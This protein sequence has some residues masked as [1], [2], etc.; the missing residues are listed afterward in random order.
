MPSD[1]ASRAC[2]DGVCSAGT[3]TDGIK[4]NDETD[5][6]CG[7]KSAP[8]C[9]D[10][11][12]CLVNAD[13]M[14][15]ACLSGR[16]GST[17]SDGIRDGD[18]TDVDCG[19][20]VAPACGTGKH[21]NVAR[22][23][24]SSV[25]MGTSCA[26]PS[27]TD[28]VKNGD[29]TDVDCGGSSAPKCGVGKGCKVSADCTTACTYQ[30]KC[31]SA[32]SCVAHHGGDTCGPGPDGD[33]NGTF[34]DCCISLPAT[35]QAGDPIV[36]DKYLITSGRLRAFVEATNGDVQGFARN[37]PQSNS[38]W[39]H[40]WDQ[41]L[42][43][44][45]AVVDQ[46]LG[47]FPYANTPENDPPD[48]GANFPV[49]FQRGQWRLGC[50][51]IDHGARTW[52]AANPV[53]GDVNAG[54]QDEL[55]EKAI[56]CIDAYFL[57]AFCIWDGGHLATLEELAGPWLA[58]GGKWPW[59]DRAASVD[60]VDN[61]PQGVDAQGRNAEDYIVH[62]FCGSACPG[63]NAEEQQE[64][65]GPFTY[66]YPAI[67]PSYEPAS[68][69]RHV[70]APGRK[71]LGNAKTGH[72]D[73]AGAGFSIT[74]IIQDPTLGERT[75]FVTSG[76]WEIHSLAPAPDLRDTGAVAAWWAYWAGVGRCAR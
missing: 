28:G 41:H 51:N 26:A 11:K 6:D 16:C 33:P 7:G 55:D 65:I 44:S 30:S 67:G 75:S 5:V 10:S 20:T 68:N 56:N 38:F 31:A 69:I 15:N 71:P 49:G 60:I 29:E 74:A 73:L 8:K 1:C 37:I 40:T 34:E 32:P 21:C 39:N 62:E 24:M 72:A 22:D 47:P 61:V 2:K 19:G 63:T 58:S 35:T 9:A 25:C 17:S 23:C 50:K 27:H 3:A 36:L 46:A 57:S 18:E 43:V 66:T 59:S 70:P 76:S 52:F 12:T 48:S 45:K 14:S 53:Q 42:P 54:T 4:N 64:F 13:C